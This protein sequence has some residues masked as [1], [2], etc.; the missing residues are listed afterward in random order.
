[1]RLAGKI[2][3]G[4]LSI[5]AVSSCFDPPEFPIIPEIAYENIRF[6]DMPDPSPFEYST[7]SLVLELSFKDGDGNLGLGSTELGSIQDDKIYFYNDR[8]YYT[9]ELIAE[10]DDNPNDGVNRC[11]DL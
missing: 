2:F 8:W 9:T 3:W 7:D 6:V 10:C 4:T 5:L 1:M 11:F